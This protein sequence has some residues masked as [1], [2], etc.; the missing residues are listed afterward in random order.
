MNR[1]KSKRSAPQNRLRLICKS[2]QIKTQ[3]MSKRAFWPAQCP[4]WSS[5]ALDLVDYGDPPRLASV[6]WRIVSFFTTFFGPSV[7]M[8][9]DSL[10]QRF[11]KQLGPP[12]GS[13]WSLS[14][15][16]LKTFLDSG[17]ASFS[18]FGSKTIF[19]GFPTPQ[20]LKKLMK[21]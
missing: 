8:L 5:R 21:I 9:L 2:N 3:Q 6:A 12:L 7:K 16:C 19:T 20:I 4:S 15:L 18:K 17:W 11:W 10:L 13:F 1:F 14:W